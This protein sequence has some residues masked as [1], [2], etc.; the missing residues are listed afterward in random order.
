MTLIIKYNKISE[1]QVNFNKNSV[2][3]LWCRVTKSNKCDNI[4]FIKDI[5]A[6][7]KNLL[8]QEFWYLNLS[9]PNLKKK[10]N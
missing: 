8:M 5:P 10:F 7:L 9:L 4:Y 6:S 1:F 2:R 3:Y